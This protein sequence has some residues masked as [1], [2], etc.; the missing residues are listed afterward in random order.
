MI[1]KE[2]K[3]IKKLGKYPQN[4]IFLLVALIISV[5]IVFFATENISKKT[6]HTIQHHSE[7][8][9]TE[10]SVNFQNNILLGSAPKILA[11]GETPGFA[12]ISLNKNN[13]EI[14]LK[15]LNISKQNFYAKEIDKEIRLVSA[16]LDK[17][18]ISAGKIN[19]LTGEIDLSAGVMVE[20]LIGNANEKFSISIPFKGSF[21]K[22]SGDLSLRGK[23]TIPPNE[24]M[25]PIPLEVTLRGKI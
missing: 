6:N 4:I 25:I 23:A 12:Q 11:K 9:L 15:E 16:V 3:I 8:S 2:K 21:N 22:L 19:S 24:L 7:Q 20:L 1:E 5:G 13:G 14:E 10:M 18:N 17:D